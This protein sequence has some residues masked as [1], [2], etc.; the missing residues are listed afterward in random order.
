MPVDA[1]LDSGQSY[2]GRAYRDC[3]AATHAHHVPII[4]AHPGMRWSSGDGVVLDVLAPGRPFLADTGDDVNENSIVAML[5]YRRPDGRE[6]RALFTGDAGQ[7]REAQLL[8]TRVDLRADVLKVG[9][10]G[11]QYASTPAFVAAVAPTLASIS[12]GRH[13]TFGHPGAST[14][15]TLA[16]F[17]AR[18]YRTDRCGALSLDVDAGIAMSMLPCRVLITLQG[19]SASSSTS[20]RIANA[21][22]RSS[23]AVAAAPTRSI[24][25]ASCGSKILP[26]R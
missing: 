6:F 16:R 8:A 13:N 15:G 4:I 9:H 7:N 14:L 5:H 23:P 22:T 19:S 12:V 2:G 17:G 25:S 21:S 10:H 11:S 18:I 20:L 1:I 26:L 3:M 24:V